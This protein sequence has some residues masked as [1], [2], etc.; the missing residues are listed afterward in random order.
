MYN[1]TE[2][3]NITDLKGFRVCQT[4]LS[5]QNSLIFHFSFKNKHMVHINFRK[6]NQMLEYLDSES[7]SSSKQS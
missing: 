3:P 7:C 1:P 6:Q 2:A 5:Q 4:Y